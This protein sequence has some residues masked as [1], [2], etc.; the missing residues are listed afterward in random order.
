MQEELARFTHSKPTR[1]IWWK[2]GSQ[3]KCFAVSLCS[4]ISLTGISLGKLDKVN[5]EEPGQ[6]MGDNPLQ[7]E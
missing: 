2:S 1:S 4:H 3:E 7:T 6:S 5:K